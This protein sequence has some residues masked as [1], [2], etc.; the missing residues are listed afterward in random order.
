MT[1]W[2]K[3]RL[4]NH[5]VSIRAILGLT[6][7]LAARCE[8]EARCGEVAGGAF[9][10]TDVGVR[11]VMSFSN[12]RQPSASQKRQGRQGRLFT[13]RS[14]RIETEPRECGSRA[15]AGAVNDIKDPVR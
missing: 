11:S 9:R 2:H 12:E 6:G 1:L 7:F 8:G 14:A 5:T 15:T 3:Q 10:R 4:H 13:L